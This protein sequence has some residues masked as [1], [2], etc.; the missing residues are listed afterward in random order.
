SGSGENL[1]EEAQA[2]SYRKSASGCGG[3]ERLQA[4]TVYGWLRVLRG[5]A[6]CDGLFCSQLLP[7]VRQCR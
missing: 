2:G 3:E 1:L 4:A 5:P 6:G 7:R